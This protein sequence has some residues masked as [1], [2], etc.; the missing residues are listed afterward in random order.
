MMS[1]CAK[2]ITTVKM[3]RILTE[4]LS[5]HRDF[6]SGLTIRS[7]SCGFFGA[8]CLSAELSDHSLD[9]VALNCVS[10]L[11]ISAVSGSHAYRISSGE[12]FGPSQA[13]GRFKTAMFIAKKD[14]VSLARKSELDY[15]LFTKIY[16]LS[17]SI[18]GSLLLELKRK[19]DARKLSVKMSRAS[20]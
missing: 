12:E 4:S 11:L 3:M 10:V 2:K 17:E 6:P 15:D 5:L 19:E 14:I 13:I 16:K 1:I 7:K 8:E 20:A 18:D 9:E